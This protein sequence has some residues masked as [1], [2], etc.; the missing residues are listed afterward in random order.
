MKFMYHCCLLT[1]LI[2]AALSAP[3]FPGPDRFT[4][5]VQSDRNENI[6]NT[7]ISLLSVDEF[8]NF[9]YIAEGQTPGV[10]TLNSTILARSATQYPGNEAQAALIYSY[11]DLPLLEVG[12]VLPPGSHYWQTGYD[13]DD[14]GYLQANDTASWYSCE[15]F[16]DPVEGRDY[17]VVAF[18]ENDDDVDHDRCEEISIKRMILL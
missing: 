9:A 1:S 7:Q 16:N 14:N 12:Q 11:N 3:T 10:F 2:E 4:L 6:N 15:D 18:F 5:M 17:P 8:K 13:F